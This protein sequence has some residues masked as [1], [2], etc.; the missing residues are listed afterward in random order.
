MFSLHK[1]WVLFDILLESAWQPDVKISPDI[2]HHA[3]ALWFLKEL[4]R[5]TKTCMELHSKFIWPHAWGELCHA[6]DHFPAEVQQSFPECCPSDTWS[7]AVTRL[8]THQMHEHLLVEEA[9][10]LGWA[11]TTAPMATLGKPVQTK[12]G[13]SWKKG[14]LSPFGLIGLHLDHPTQWDTGREGCNP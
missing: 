4:I 8:A 7:W 1:F 13:V 10:K 6:R 14:H 3:C 11:P 12:E 5:S 2:V 9:A